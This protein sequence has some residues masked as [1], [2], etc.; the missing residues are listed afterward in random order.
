MLMESGQHQKISSASERSFGLVFSAVSAV[1]AVYTFWTMGV[2]WV[3]IVLIVLSILFL[4][5]G[6]FAPGILRIPNKLWA[7]LGLLLAFVITPVIMVLIFAVAIAPSGL[8]MRLF[9]RDPMNRCRDANI[10][11][12]WIKRENQPGP[13]RQQF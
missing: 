1:A 2:I 6:L 9:G 11:S 13:M 4:A 10:A 5:L 12:Y 3:G 7:K 8:L